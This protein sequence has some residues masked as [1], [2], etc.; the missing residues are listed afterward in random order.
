[1]KAKVKYTYIYININIPNNWIG[2]YKHN[3]DPTKV[4]NAFVYPSCR[5]M[6]SIQYKIVGQQ[7]EAG[8]IPA[9][10]YDFLIN[11]YLDMK[12]V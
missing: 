1:M 9:K 11:A 5:R 10:T 12:V 2:Y 6:T 7:M 3:H 4:A 8:I